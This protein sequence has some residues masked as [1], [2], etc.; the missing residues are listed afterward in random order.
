MEAC[1]LRR[2]KYLRK[3]VLFTGSQCFLPDKVHLDTTFGQA[4]TEYDQRLQGYMLAP[5]PSGLDRVTG[6]R[7]V[8]VP[9]EVCP[10]GGLALKCD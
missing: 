10:A 9:Q 2:A 4:L 1:S 3:K 5:W 7:F 8:Q 6:T